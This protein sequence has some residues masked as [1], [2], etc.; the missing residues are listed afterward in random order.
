MA[1][2][3][4]LG[5]VE[6]E[7]LGIISPHEHLFSDITWAFTPPADPIEHKM[8]FEPICMRNLGVLRRNVSFARDNLILDD[9]DL[10]SY[11]LREFRRAGGGTLADV[12][13]NGINRSPKMLRNAAIESGVNIVM[14]CG[15][16]YA[17]SHPKDMD[18]RTVECLADEMLMEL[19]DGIGVAKTK[20]GVIGELGVSDRIYPNEKKVLEAGAIAQKKTGVGVHVHMSDQPVD[21]NRFP[22]GLDMLDIFEKSGAN[23]S[24]VCLNHIGV[25]M[26]VD[27]EYCTE[28]LKRGAYIALDT[29]GHE[30]Y[31]DNMIPY[32]FETDLGRVR[33][34]KKLCDKGFEKQILISCDICHKTLLHTYGGWGYDHIITNIIPMMRDEGFDE[35]TIGRLTAGNPADFLDSDM[36]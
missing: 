28:V 8:A 21:G 35:K 15:Y 33:A 24:K 29:F 31:K 1:V 14:G 4:V 27:I 23:V 34:I 19:T 26:G 11:E 5:K 30:F 2:N 16:Y 18:D 12:T 13:V 3:T 6:K 25:I 17:A 36:I 9:L 32:P 10:A 20:A 22:F 7:N